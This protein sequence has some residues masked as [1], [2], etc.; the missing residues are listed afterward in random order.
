VDLA[1]VK[2][3]E[4]ALKPRVLAPR[5]WWSTHPHC[6]H[7]RQ[8]ARVSAQILHEILS[9]HFELQIIYDNTVLS[10]DNRPP[11]LHC[12]IERR[13]ARKISLLHPALSSHTVT[14]PSHYCTPTRNTTHSLPSQEAFTGL[15]LPTDLIEDPIHSMLL[16]AA[17]EES[18]N[19]EDMAV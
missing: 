15:G 5:P 8:L 1:H 10:T 11:I 3:V 7:R 14:T 19:L 2:K 12:L 13:S 17:I 4:V 16:I 18:L 9:Q 6:I